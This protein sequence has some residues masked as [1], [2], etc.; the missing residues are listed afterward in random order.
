MRCVCLREVLFVLHK[1]NSVF[2]GDCILGTG[3]TKFDDLHTYMQS[4]ERLLSLCPLRLYPGHGPVVSD[5]S[6]K[7]REYIAHRRQ[8]EQQI[9]TALRQQQRPVTSRE[10]VDLIYVGLQAELVPS[11]QRNVDQHLRKLAIDGF[12]YTADNDRWAATLD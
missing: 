5:G 12:V 4:L 3:S 10:L 11:A 7:I 1:E 6:G 2:T 8:R 9:L